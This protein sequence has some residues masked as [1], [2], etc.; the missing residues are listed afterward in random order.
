MNH[1]IIWSIALAILTHLT[2]HSSKAFGLGQNLLA[3]QN[4][5]A[6]EVS[7]CVLNSGVVTPSPAWDTPSDEATYKVDY[8]FTCGPGFGPDTLNIGIKTGTSSL[9][10]IPFGGKG[11]LPPITGRGDL[12]ILDSDPD[13]TKFSQF[14]SS[15][16]L[17]INGASVAPSADQKQKWRSELSDV[18]QR[19]SDDE[20]AKQAFDDLQELAATFRLMGDIAAI[21]T[22]KIEQQDFTKFRDEAIPAVAGVAQIIA[23]SKDLGL[24][25]ADLAAL[26]R[27]IVALS[28]LNG[29]DV[30]KN[31][32]GS[33]KSF[34]DFL[35]P[36]D[37][38]IFKR[39]SDLATEKN[40]ATNRSQ[41]QHFADLIVACQLRTAKL[42]ALLEIGQ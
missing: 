11:S 27:L 4:E 41:S 42:T 35:S 3:C 26:T 29:P 15:C 36:D 24:T 16:Q 14:A 22:T 34:S 13:N 2:A 40:A 6:G 20:A 8:D 28:S 7:R 5:D 1:L 37:Q 32:D 31:P 21:F 39:L 30:W 12:V 17:I 9:T 33:Y 23:K 38:T 25:Q 18:K 19:C 10:H